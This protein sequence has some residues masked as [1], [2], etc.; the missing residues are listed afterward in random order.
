MKFCEKLIILRKRRGL[1]QQD[2][3]SEMGVSRQSVY[4]W[5]SGHSYPEA[6]KLMEIKR[7][8]GISVDELLDETEEFHLPEEKRSERAAVE[9]PP[10]PILHAERERETNARTQSQTGEQRLAEVRV[11]AQKE[12]VP[13]EEKKL[14]ETPREPVKAALH[15]PPHV[16]VSSGPK[17]KKQNPF[18]EIVGT[19]FGRKR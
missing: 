6:P 2:F 10:A 13:H 15:R 12:A 4:K 11:A 1:T 17:K 18:I 7:L 5:E 16:S 19:I 9:I 8:Y 3:A 14:R